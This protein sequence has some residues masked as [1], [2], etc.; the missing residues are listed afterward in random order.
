MWTFSNKQSDFSN[1]FLK[2]S[3]FWG[4]NFLYYF[5]WQ[6]ADDILPLWP[7]SLTSI[8][9]RSVWLCVRTSTECIVLMRLLRSSDGWYVM[10]TDARSVGYKGEL[11]NRTLHLKWNERAYLLLTEMTHSKNIFRIFV[12]W[13]NICRQKKG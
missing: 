6:D 1:V 11:E 3:R 13:K 12:F 4:N 9:S 10:I 2:K 7:P 8:I 5:R